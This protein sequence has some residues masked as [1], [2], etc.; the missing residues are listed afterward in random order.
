ME[1]GIIITMDGPAGTG[2]STVARLLAKKLGLRYLDTGALYRIITYQ[3]MKRAINPY[4]KAPL[5]K[6]LESLRIRFKDDG[7][8][9]LVYLHD[10]DIT[11]SIRL[12]I[13]TEFVFHYAELPLVR[14]AML[15]IQRRL[16]AKGNIVGE[17]RDLGSIVFP[18][19][20]I[21]FYLD[22]SASERA[23]RRWKELKSKGIKMSYQKVLSEIKSRDWRDRNRP[24]APLKQV[25]DAIRVDTTHLSIKEVVWK[26]YKIV[27][28]SFHAT[29]TL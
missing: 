6:C 18:W 19:A 1:R 7:K 17:G 29:R 20:D 13:I 22:A 10:K 9:Q 28:A 26:L 8:K 5:K 4:N 11:E 25:P 16:G 15:K 24:I 21:K 27:K 3:A 14:K 2:K 12:P 23:R